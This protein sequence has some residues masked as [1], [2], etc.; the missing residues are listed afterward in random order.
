MLISFLLLVPLGLAAALLF[1]RKWRLAIPAV[2]LWTVFEGATRKWGFPQYQG[3]IYLIKDAVLLAAYIGFFNEY[4]RINPSRY[5]DAGLLTLGGIYTLYL[6]ILLMNPTSPSLLLSLVGIKNH[7]T[8]LPLALVVPALISSEEALYKFIRIFLY[9]TILISLIGLY[10][11]TQ[12]ADAWINLSVSF[13][14]VAVEAVSR[15]GEQGSGAFRYGRV[16]TSGT[17]SYIGGMITYVILAVPM[18]ATTLFTNR[19]TPMD[20]RVAYLALML[21][22]GASF[23]TGARTPI[24]VLALGLPILFLLSMMRGLISPKMFMRLI[25]GAVVVGFGAAFVFG[26]AI[27]ALIFRSNNADSSSVRLLS[28]FI[29]TINA[30]NVTPIFGTGLGTNSNAAPTIMQSPYSWWLNGHNF[31]LETARIMQEVGL[32]GFLIAYFLRIYVVV[33]A[34]RYAFR[35]TNPYYVALCLAAAFYFTVHIV[36]FVVNNPLAAVYYYA[37]LG[38]VLATGRLAAEHQTV[39][40]PSPN[41]LAMMPA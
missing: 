14:N 15:F 41:R 20:R 25:V 19:F 22:L 7:L 9:F 13:D 26:D 10:Q 5:M 2:I 1:A 12:P 3:Q 11:F 4:R 34:V 35:H 23:T 18:I 37:L 21:C 32:F 16:R 27:Q 33:L 38:M 30:F 39:R 17:F 8:Y 6:L 31:E 29:E 24:F 40:V 36:L 28:P